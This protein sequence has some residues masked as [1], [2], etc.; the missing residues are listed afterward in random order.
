[1]YQNSFILD[2]V[3]LVSLNVI[4]CKVENNS[5]KY[6]V[7]IIRKIFYQPLEFVGE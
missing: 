5:G 1:M 2:K 4:V 7:S 3:M 6:E